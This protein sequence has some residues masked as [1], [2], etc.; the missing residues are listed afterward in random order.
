MALMFD[1]EKVN[2]ARAECRDDENPDTASPHARRTAIVAVVAVEFSYWSVMLIVHIV[3]QICW[4][5]ISHPAF[6]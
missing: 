5:I 2:D 4:T 3:S 6:R 1:E